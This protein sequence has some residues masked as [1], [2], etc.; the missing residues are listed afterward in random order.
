VLPLVLTDAILRLS[1]SA[2]QHFSFYGYDTLFMLSEVATLL[3][4]GSMQT[5]VAEVASREARGMLLA[6]LPWNS[7]RSARGRP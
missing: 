5:L 2:A 7:R 3:R 6:H 1:V 4:I